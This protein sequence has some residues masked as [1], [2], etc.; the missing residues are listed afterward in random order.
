VEAV[1][2]V[3]GSGKLLTTRAAVEG[4]VAEQADHYRRALA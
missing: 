1:E 2:A 3:E 4:S